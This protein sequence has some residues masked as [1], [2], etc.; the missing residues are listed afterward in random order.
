MTLSEERLAAKGIPERSQV[1]FDA[2]YG[3]CRFWLVGWRAVI[4]FHAV[5]VYNRLGAYTFTSPIKSLN[6]LKMASGVTPRSS[7]GMLDRFTQ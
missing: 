1:L 4:V 7:P 3:F 2:D 6:D 5:G